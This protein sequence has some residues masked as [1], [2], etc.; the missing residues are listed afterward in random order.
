MNELHARIEALQRLI[1]EWRDRSARGAPSSEASLPP[2]FD[3]MLDALRALAA[4]AEHLHDQNEELIEARAKIEAEHWQYQDLFEMA[5]DGYVV[6]DAAGIIRKAN[7]AAEGLLNVPRLAMEGRPLAMFVAAADRRILRSHI[8]AL[9]GGSRARQ[10]EMLIKT[11]GRDVLPVSVRAAAVCPP[12]EQAITLRCILRDISERKQAEQVGRLTRDIL[13]IFAR[14]QTRKEYLEAIVD[15]VRRWSGCRCVGVRVVNDRREIPYE[16]ITGF[17]REFW[18]L[19]NVL[20]LDTDVCA[21]VRICAGCPEPQDVAAMTPGGSFRIDN[22]TE[23]V[24]G[25]TPEALGRF[26]GNC[27]KS[28]FLSIAVVP[29][30]HG[31]EVVGAIHLADERPGMVPLETIGALEAAGSLIGEAMNRFRMAEAL[32]ESEQRYRS[33]V[34]TAQEGI[35]VI[36]AEARTTFVNPKMAE[37]LGYTT[38]EMIGRSLLDFLDDEGKAAAQ[39]DLER[40]RSGATERIDFRFLR[41]DGSDLW[42]ILAVHPL[43]DEAGRYDGVLGMLTDITERKRAEEDLRRANKA[44]RMIGECDD[45]LVHAADEN[46]LLQQ[47]CRIIVDAGGYR[48]AW[49]GYAGN[50]E[51]K[52]VRPVG[53]AGFEDGYLETLTVT[54]ADNLFGQGPTGTAIRTGRPCVVQNIL[55]DPEYE[56]WRAEATRRGYGSSVA[57]PLMAGGRAFGALNIYAAQPQAFDGGEVRLLMEL[58]DDLAYGITALR[59]RA[60]LRRAMDALRDSNELL[61]RMFGSIHVFVAYMDR[62]F[63]FIRVNAAYAQA[64][65]HDPAFFVGKNHFDLYPNEENQ[66]IFCRVVETGE[67]FVVHARPFIYAANPERGTTHWNW[68]LEPVRDAGGQVRGLILSLL[69]VTDQV[70]VQERIEAERQRLFSVLNMLPGFVLL[71]APDHTARF[72]NHHFLDIFGDPNEK[73]CYTLMQGRD[74]PCDTCYVKEILQTGV[75]REWEWTN[76]AGRDYHVWGYPFSDT[77]GSRLVLELGVDITE[78][79]TL[80]REILE[81][82]AEERRSIGHDLHDGLGQSL[83]GISFLS[84][85]LAERLTGLG[86]P[87]AP[88]AVNIAELVSQTVAQARAMSH[89]LCPVEL[90][91]DG[92]E[93]ALT[94]MA[95]NVERAFGIECRFRCAGPIPIQDPAVLRH[96]YHIT[97]EAVTNATKHANPRRI[98]IDC[99]VDDGEFVLRVRDNGVGIP[100]PIPKEAGMGLRI[101]KYRAD[102]IGAA[103]AIEPNPHGGTRVTCRLPLGAGTERR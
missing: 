58:A 26:R 27:I 72:A 54:W 96:L 17:S 70:R 92:F 76:E 34:E 19:E 65:G 42:A 68:R 82:S 91:E 85:V 31:D 15:N 83:T 7:R 101:M 6:T 99:G 11:R 9:A 40:R 60:D 23:F 35:W 84:K 66:A 43:F 25:L 45:A 37:M 59:A 52:T 39:A 63:N 87:E 21:C 90:T 41:K 16:A 98:A 46:Q 55:T 81:I 80:E 86:S 49:V 20:S 61:E 71:H 38:R 3:Q 74:E 78:R 44:L 4:T 2:M 100:D 50:D 1:A 62:D 18:E 103:L 69:D 33:L 48:M 79:R 24:K 97:Q 36:D 102:M 56:T 22:A 95:K 30:R 14:K 12:G 5:P 8:T 75:P 93:H 10:F 94:E 73:P 64:D 89:G 67:P 32:R 28:G 29:I 13:A 53:Q 51:T 57:L 77:D 47:V 88:A